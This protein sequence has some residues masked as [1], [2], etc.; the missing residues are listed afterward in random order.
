MFHG[1]EIHELR[2]ELG[3]GVTEFAQLFGAAISTVYRWEAAETANVDGLRRNIFLVLINR[4]KEMPPEQRKAWGS[5]ISKTI[6][7]GGSLCAL[8]VALKPVCEERAR[9][10]GW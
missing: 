6:A 1:S 8:Y 3:L 5:D 10:M 4:I 2:N 9:K 7:L